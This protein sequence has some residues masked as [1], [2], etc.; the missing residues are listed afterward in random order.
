MRDPTGL[1][2]L[3][4][5]YPVGKGQ[6]VRNSLP[7]T[8]LLWAKKNDSTVRTFADKTDAVIQTKD[9]GWSR[10]DGGECKVGRKTVVVGLLSLKKQVP[11]V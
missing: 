7:E 8:R 9:L 3:P 6:S 11:R 1:T 2:I 10:S 5:S 4:A